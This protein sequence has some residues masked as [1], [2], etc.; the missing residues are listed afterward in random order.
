MRLIRVLILSILLALTSFQTLGQAQTGTPVFG[1]FGGGSDV[2]NLANL[3]SHWTIP[4]LHKFGRGRNFNFD[5]TYDSSVWVP[6]GSSGNTSW[7]PVSNW[8][9]ATSDAGLGFIVQT[10]LSGVVNICNGQFFATTF[11]NSWSY[12][13]AVGTVHPFPGTNQSTSPSSSPCGNYPNNGFTATATDGSGYTITVF[14]NSV[15]SLYSADGSLI[16]APVNQNFGAMTGSTS[17][18]QDRN[19]NKI[20]TDG[21]GHFY[22]TL[23]STVAVLTLS[24]S[25]TST[26]PRKFTY[27]TPSGSAAYQVNY[28][29]YTVATNFGVSGTGEYKSTAAVPLVSSIILPDNSQYSFTYE[30]TP[31]SCTPYSGTT[32]TTAR[33]KSVTFPTGGTIS[34]T[35]SC[36]SNGILPDGIQP[37]RH[38]LP[39]NL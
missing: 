17:S 7:Q 34:Y 5:L 15:T 30:A 31:G 32:C 2:I 8:G 13:D 16:N 35:Y 19:G 26:S 10:E 20:T 38:P 9:W 24:G 11:T 18:I 6:V 21:N 29:N 37:N 36:G 12:V 4:I 27:T 14:G 1:S 25:G 33:I 23:S 39:G 22:D 28:T 3:N